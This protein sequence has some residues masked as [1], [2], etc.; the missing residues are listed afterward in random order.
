MDCSFLDRQEQVHTT[1]G[2]ATPQA[3]PLSALF[4]DRIWQLSIKMVGLFLYYSKHP[5]L[6]R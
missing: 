1:L 4:S 2:L 5:T 6:M 3:A